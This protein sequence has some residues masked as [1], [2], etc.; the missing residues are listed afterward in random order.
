MPVQYAGFKLRPVGF[1]DR[2]PAPD[3]PPPET[4]GN[5]GHAGEG[6]TG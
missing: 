2:N 5:C 1:F 4:N 6:G 3:V